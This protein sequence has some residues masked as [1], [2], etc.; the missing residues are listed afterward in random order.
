MVRLIF[1]FV[2]LALSPLT[3]TAQV[4]I[5]I[6]QQH[7]RK[8]QTIHASL[9][10]T[11]SK[12]VTFCIQVGQ[13]SPKGSGEIEATPSPFWVQGNNNGKWST[14]LIG[15][16]VGNF[17]NPEVLGAGKSLE[18]PFRLGASGQMRLRMNYWSGSLQSL[19]CI[20]S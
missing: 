4:K 20:A 14:L 10:N 17:K 15:P 2:V 18:F 5:Y 13:T 8:Y 3:A 9:E 12:P 11:G 7:A 1:A 6:A 16:E 19:N